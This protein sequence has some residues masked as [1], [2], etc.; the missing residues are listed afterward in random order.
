M[1]HSKPVLECPALMLA[2][3]ASGQGKT[4]ITAAMARYFR[5]QGLRVR[6][7]KAGPDYLDPKVLTLASGAPVEPLDMWMAGDEYCQ[8]MLYQA[9]T[10]A[11]LILIEGVMGLFD[12]E[13]SCAD[14][15]LRFDIPVALVMNVKGMAQTVAAV[16]LGLASYQPT[17]NVVGVIANHCST[18]RH[19]ELIQSALPD[20][21][22]MLACLRSDESITLPERHLGLIQVEEQQEH[23]D[24]LINKGAHWWDDGLARGTG[25]DA[26]F[27]A[28]GKTQFIP[29]ETPPAQLSYPLKGLTI[30]VAKDA[31]F[32]FIY[33]ANLLFL[34]NYGAQISYFSPLSDTKIP[35]ADAIWLPGGYPELHRDTLAQ[36]HALQA[37]LRSAYE[38]G[39]PILAECGGLLFCLEGLTDLEGQRSPMCGLIKGEGVMRGKRG[40]QGMQ[41]AML[42]EGEVRAHAHHRSRT[43]GT[44]A[45]IAHGKRQRHS[46]PGEAIY[47]QNAL[48]ATYLHLFFPSNPEAICRLFLG[49]FATPEV[50]I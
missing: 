4:T 45:P 39:L 38:A 33:D 13:P 31:A 36:N 18:A 6:V 32:T 22:P 26:F 24:A 8:T 12:G 16:A 44:P 34:K 15:A 42:P 48:T 14:L 40:C 23:I 11:D 30:A 35:A 1:A 20:H 43:E 28:V 7:F 29:T 3:P 49:D 37:S 2:A 41:S 10:E 17:L 47:R 21:L 5:L 50:S 19:A 9:S 25:L 27:D 46:A